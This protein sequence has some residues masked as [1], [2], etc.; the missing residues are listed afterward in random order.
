VCGNG[1]LEEGEEC[2]GNDVPLT[3]EDAGYY[4]GEMFCTNG[5]DLNDAECHNCGNGTVDVNDG[6]ECEGDA[7]IS[8]ADLGWDDGVAECVSCDWNE[9]GCCNLEGG[10]CDGDGECC[11]EYCTCGVQGICECA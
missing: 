10:E 3:C 5:C 6:E 4:A 11:G 9:E 7:G 8:C 1:I 2:D